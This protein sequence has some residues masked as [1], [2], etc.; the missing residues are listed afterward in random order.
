MSAASISFFV[1]ATLAVIAALAGVLARRPARSL[2]CFAV[3]PVALALPLLQLGAETVA[4]ILV[5]GGMLSLALLA[6]WVAMSRSQPSA[7]AR[8]RPIAAWVL[9]GAGLLA[10][11]W[12]LLA[13]GSRQVIEPG[14]SLAST[15]GATRAERLQ[16][17]LFGRWM[18]P[19]ELL[20][21]IALV[22]LIA[23]VLVRLPDADER[24]AGEE[25]R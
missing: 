20:G 16:D 18:V 2:G 15:E 22:V 8:P 14:K 5:L 21:L 10:F 13:T 3:V 4:A 1:A 7:P 17:L 12:V 23:A 24:R 19:V 6:G 9:A 11:V 25:G